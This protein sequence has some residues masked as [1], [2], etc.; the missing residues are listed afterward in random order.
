MDVY[1]VDDSLNVAAVIDSAAWNVVGKFRSYVEH[2]DLAAV[3]WFWVLEHP[4]KMEELQAEESVRLAAWKLDKAVWKEME[5][6]ARRE[7]AQKVGFKA[8]DEVFYTEAMIKSLLPRVLAND[9]FP[10]RRDREEIRTPTDAA[11]SGDFLASYLDVQRAWKSDV[12]TL[13]ERTIVE[14]LLIVGASQEETAAFVGVTRQTAARSFDRAIRKLQ[15]FLGGPPVG[16]CPYTCECHEGRLRAR[17][18]TRG[19]DAGRNQLLG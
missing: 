12:L 8:K 4:A 14:Y 3:G 18:G 16:D 7:R 1:T 19:N 2:E 6:Y 17:P 13:Q 5:R 11:E 9:P 10:E 15:S